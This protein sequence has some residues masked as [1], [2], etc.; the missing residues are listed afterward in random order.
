MG[1]PHRLDRSGVIPAAWALVTAGGRQ[2]TAPPLS[3]IGCPVTTSATASAASAKA[4]FAA[5]S[6]SS[7]ARA[8]GDSRAAELT[9]ELTTTPLVEH[10]RPADHHLTFSA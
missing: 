9:S 8:S 10:S 4:R 7:R 3:H 2:P 1:S 6:R 5:P